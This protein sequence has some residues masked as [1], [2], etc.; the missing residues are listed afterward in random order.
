MAGN[1][2]N[3]TA[4]L[5][6]PHGGLVQ[7]ISANARVRAVGAPV[8]LL[9]DTFIV[10]G[11]PFQIPAT[12]PIPSPCVFVRWVMPDMRVR[13]NGTFT[14]SQSSVGIC[15]SAAQVPQGLVSVVATQT[16][17]KSQ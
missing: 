13:V 17:V 5:L 6:C 2:L 8:A 3:T 10:S 12:P 14:L 1:S 9:T 7:I 11:C 15:Q 16:R 4:Q